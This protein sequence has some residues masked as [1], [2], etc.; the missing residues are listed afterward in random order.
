MELTQA[1]L[2]EMFEYN[3]E[4][5]LFRNLKS[6]KVWIQEDERGYI[7]IQIGKKRYRAH[8]LAYLYVEGEMPRNID[9]I[10]GVGS[11]NRWANLRSCS[12]SENCRNRGIG[13]NSVSGIKNVVW[14]EQAKRWKVVIRVDGVMYDYGFFFDLHIAELVAIGARVKHHGEFARVC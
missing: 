8:R 1:Q 2:K 11:D 3:P 6:G 4:T 10:N 13:Q 5:G 9:H 7:R 14:N 12:Q